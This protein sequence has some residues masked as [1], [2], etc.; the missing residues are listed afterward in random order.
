METKKYS[1]YAQIEHDLEILRVEREIHY[2]KIRLSFD[3]TKESLVPSK[4]ISLLGTIYENVFSG[5]LGTIIK[6]LIPILINWYL[7]KKR[8][9]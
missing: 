7:N 1:S 9:D 8:G 4:T 3:K 2:Q 6:T 5:T